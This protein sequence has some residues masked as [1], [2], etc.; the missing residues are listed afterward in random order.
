MR[1]NLITLATG[2]YTYFLGQLVDSAREFLPDLE[3][4]YVLS[5]DP[6]VSQKQVT[7]LP[8]GH[9]AWPLSTFMR[10]NAIDLHANSS[11][12]FDADLVLYSDADMRFVGEVLLPDTKGLIAVEHPGY[13]DSPQ[14]KYPYERDTRNPFH[15]RPGEGSKYFAGGVQGG[16]ANAYR[17]AVH[18]MAEKTREA[19]QKALIPVWH[20]ESVWN[21]YLAENPPSLILSKDF[22]TPETEQ[23]TESKILALDKDH[24]LFRNTEAITSKRFFWRR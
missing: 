13:V 6:S 20:D 19:A 18:E 24:H 3:E 21:R 14:A 1:I 2:K 12:L 22:C 4:I 16:S 7:W 23:N 8:W 11:N 9:F 5:D 15:V 17:S 10:F